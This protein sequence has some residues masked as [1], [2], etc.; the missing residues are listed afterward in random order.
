MKTFRLVYLVGILILAGCGKH[1]KNNL[2][3][4]V[5]PMIGTAA[6]G[7]T[8]PGATTPF[9]MVQL[10]PDTGTEGWDWCSGYHYSDSSIIGFS[11]THL[12]GTGGADLGDILVM[13]YIGE[14]KWEAGM[15]EDPDAGY[16]SRFSRTTEVAQAGYYEVIL[17]DYGIK[18]E[19][20]AT[21]RTGIH[22]YRF[23]KSQEARIIVDLQ[24]GIS[25]SPKGCWIKVN[26]NNELVGLRRS[27]G[28]AADQNVYFVAQFSKEFKAYHL[29]ADGRL[30]TNGDIAKGKFSKV[31]LDFATSNDEEV[32][33]KVGIS[34]VDVDGA[35][36]NLADEAPHWSFNQYKDAARE[37]WNQQLSKI[38]VEGGTDEQKTVFYTS[39]Y[40]ASITPN[41]FSDA[42]GRYR[43]MDKQI[44]QS[45]AHNMYH[46]FSLWDTFRATHPLFTLMAPEKNEEF[47]QTMLV[48]SEQHGLLPVWELAGNE[49]GTMIGYHS[50][51]VIWDA[52]QKGY[53]N[54]DAEKAFEAMKKSANMNHIGLADYK[55]LGFI[56]MER[57]G[58]S[59][60]KIVEYAYDDWCIAQMA[61]A[62]GK[63]KD[64]ALFSKRAQSY[65]NVFDTEIG[66]MRGRAANGAWRTPFN[67]IESSILG[68]GDFTEGNSWHYTFFAPHDMNTL[69]ELYGGDEAFVAKI[70]ELFDL[71]SVRTNDDAHDISG[72]LG[73][74][75]QGNE[76][77][78][79]VAYLYN[80]AGQP[81]KT[82]EKVTLIMDSLYSAQPDGLCGNEDCGQMSAWYAFSAMGLYPVTPG[83]GKYTIGS[84]IFDKVTLNLENGNT[85]SFVTNNVNSDNIYIQSASLNGSN[86]TKSYLSHEV[87]EKGGEIVFEMG[88]QPN[89]K[90]GSAVEDRPV[91]RA[92][93]SNWNIKP[94]EESVVFIPFANDDLVLFGK[95]KHVTLNSYS[96]D[97]QIRYTLDGSEPDENS[98]VYS[99]PITLRK[100]TTLRAKGFVK[101]MKTSEEFKRHYIR[102]IFNE[103][104]SGCPLIHLSWPPAGNYKAMGELALL[105]GELGSDNFHDGH[106]LGFNTDM[107]AT[108]QLCRKERVNRVSVGFLQNTGSWI[109]LPESLEVSVSSDGKSYKTV[110]IVKN[111][112]TSDD[113]QVQR[114]EFAT[115]LIKVNAKYVKV[116]AKGLPQLPDWHPGAGNRPWI[117][118]DE[119]IIER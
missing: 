35:R 36:G 91:N 32:V 100:T 116:K 11:H 84:P 31:I 70:D 114:V 115:E 38:E 58:N 117:F 22:R 87:I 80:Y 20:T 52:W 10:S 14:L 105:N 79:H 64:Y 18:A 119:I 99:K 39:L 60:S 46:I 12:S 61:N 55:N 82:Q 53:R 65:K 101:G 77:S 88:H 107:E 104:G 16:R 89:K 48:Q 29:S 66:F 81:W 25:D 5:D 92:N 68:S 54:F 33:V 96:K 3:Q 1:S 4:Y 76:P 13:P 23:P 90:F 67:P 93:P 57:E 63:K 83:D 49:T 113:R 98:K 21:P 6:H 110:S 72:L 103:G 43:G 26:G 95:H 112:I 109:F 8:F 51:P 73:Q 102:A 118:S 108:I 40:H 50:I 19:L 85:F 44:H 41:L 42:D 15:K 28:W 86:Y 56:P 47:I 97:S 69:M 27:Q 71:E 74:Y 106:W 30:V 59:V 34:A 75:A 37:L 78:H 94:L 9:G 2:T 111:P 17:D 62:L 7:H 24:H 45:D